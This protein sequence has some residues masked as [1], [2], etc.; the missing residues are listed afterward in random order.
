MYTLIALSC[1]VLTNSILPKGE[2]LAI[3]LSFCTVLLTV[4]SALRLK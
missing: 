1:T 2:S 3:R 4:L